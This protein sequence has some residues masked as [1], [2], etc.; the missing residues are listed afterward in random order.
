MLCGFTILAA[1][2]GAALEL[3]AGASA[4][5]TVVEGLMLAAIAVVG[6]VVASRVPGNPSGWLV[7]VIPAS[8]ATTILGTGV[9]HD[10]VE[11][12][13]GTVDG[14]ALAGPWLASWSWIPAILAIAVFPQLFPTGRPLTRRWRV[15][16]WTAAA[17]A[18]PLFV[19]TAFERG[20]FEDFLELRNPLGAPGTLGEIVAILGGVGFALLLA[21]LAGAVASIV[22]RWRRSSGAERQQLKWVATAALVFPVAF[23]APTD[24]G[25]GE[26]LGF[27]LL[28]LALFLLAAAV[29]V[30]ILRYRL[31]D[32]DV[33]IRRTLVYAVLTATLAAT[34]LVSVL[35]LGI[36][37]PAVR[38]WRLR[39]RRWPPRLRS[40]RCGSGSSSRSGPS[41]LPPSLRRRAHVD[42]L[43]H[44]ATRRARP[45]CGERGTPGRRGRD[46]AAVAR[47][48]V[49]ARGTAMSEST[50]AARGLG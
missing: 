45:R 39:C 50:S 43:R 3:A 37:L 47:D 23:A 35:L 10:L 25:A 14:I 41:L 18:L 34:Y 49:A 8:F 4:P 15:L 46:D 11:Q 33:V 16:L 27:A 31:Y 36:V 2:I 19:G 9:L 6:A 5:Y 30:A 20:R 44:A 21:T 24:D 42:L 17:S 12:E 28:L 48:R 32:I 26:D 1:V 22:V 40:A 7:S 29:A 38:I 13:R